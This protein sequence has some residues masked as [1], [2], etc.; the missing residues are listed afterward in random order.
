M[1]RVNRMR[2]R[3]KKRKI[4]MKNIIMNMLVLAQFFFCI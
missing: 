1:K 2:M 3:R 4:K